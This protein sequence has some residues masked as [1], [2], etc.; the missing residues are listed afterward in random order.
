MGLAA[1]DVDGDG[2]PDVL[3]TSYSGFYAAW[4]RNDGGDP[5]TWSKHTISGRL[6]GAHSA[7]ADDMDADGDLDVVVTATDLGSVMVY[8]NDGGD[9]VAWQEL[10]LSDAVAGVRYAC[11]ADIDDDGHLDVVATGFGGTVAWWRNSRGDGSRW[12]EETITDSR[13]GGHYV[14]VSDIDGDGN[15][16]VLV[17]AYSSSTVSWFTRDGGQWSEH[18]VDGAFGEALTALAGDLDGDGDLDVVGTSPELGEIAWWEVSKPLSSGELVSTILDTGTSGL[19]MALDWQAEVPAGCRLELQVRSGDQADDLGDWSA[20]LEPSCDIAEP[21]GRY[22]QYRVLLNGHGDASPVLYDIMLNERTSAVTAPGEQVTVIPVAAHVDGAEGTSWVSDVVLHNAGSNTVS[23]NLFWLPRRRDN[24]SAQP[25]PVSVEP[26][27]SL[28]LDDVVR[29]FFAEESGAGAILIGADAALQVSSRTYNQTPEGTYGQYIPG[30]PLHEAADTETR[31]VLLQLTEDDRFRTNIGFANLRD[32]TLD[33]EVAL[34]RN[35]GSTLGTMAASLPPFSAEQLD[36]PLRGFS[37]V[38]DAYAVISAT[39][40]DARYLAYASTVDRLSGDPVYISPVA[41]SH[42]ALYIPAAAHV[43]GMA[44]TDWRTDLEVFSCGDI[45]ARY[46]LEQLPAADAE[47]PMFNLD[48]AVAVRYDDVLSSV[49]GSGG[50]AA[51]LVR[52]LAGEVMV[53][54]RT[55]NQPGSGTYGQFIPGQPPETAISEGVEARLI[56]LSSSADEGSGFRTNIG[57][58]NAAAE[59]V[60]ISVRLYSADGSRLG[61]RSYSVPGSDY[62]QV[63]AVFR[64]VN[65]GDV[66]DG[67]AVISSQTPGA[68]YFAYASVIDQRTGDPVYQPARTPPAS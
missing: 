9:P 56:Q 1:A 59:T 46:R 27:A 11:F 66:P 14:A 35:D 61:T 55:Y 6:M 45:Q 5:I 65:A 3:S 57:F 43:G 38:A 67:Y 24:L 29:S 18:I 36:G 40:P 13:S 16:D 62:L 21:L 44:G 50:S 10:M 64:K 31:P 32:T 47:T 42:E 51:L 4:W 30:V 49:L 41:P 28:R 63:G 2:D 68:H 8:R 7:L 54:S 53:T 26:A 48:Q 37:P 19:R 33:L 22:L 52:V 34:H 20:A 15:N 17:A 25:F 12:Q 60:E 23:S 58:A 39:G